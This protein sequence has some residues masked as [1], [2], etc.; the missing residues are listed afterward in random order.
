MHSRRTLSENMLW[1]L[2][3]VLGIHFLAVWLFLGPPDAAR[4][5]NGVSPR[6]LE[7]WTIYPGQALDLEFIL[8]PPG[9]GGEDLRLVA[10]FKKPVTNQGLVLKAGGDRIHGDIDDDQ[11]RYSLTTTTARRHLALANQGDLPVRLAE[12]HLRNYAA[13]NPNFPRLAVLWA[14]WEPER[15]VVLAWLAAVA[16]GGLLITLGGWL[17]PRPIIFWTLTAGPTLLLAAAGLGAAAGGLRP[18]LAWDCFWLSG[19]LGPALWLLARAARWAWGQAGRVWAVLRFL[20]RPRTAVFM[21]LMIAA[22]FLPPILIGGPPSRMPFNPGPLNHL[23]DYR[24]D[25]VII[26]NSMAYTRINYKK[27]EELVPGRKVTLV[28]LP[29][30]RMDSWYLM[31]KHYVVASGVKPKR[32]FLFFRDSHL[33]RVYRDRSERWVR[34]NEALS[35]GHDPEFNQVMYGSPD[36]FKKKLATGLLDVFALGN[37]GFYWRKHLKQWVTVTTIPPGFAEKYPV[38]TDKYWARKVNDRFGLAKLRPDIKEEYLEDRQALFDFDRELSQSLLPYFIDLAHKHDIPLMMIRVQCN[39]EPDGSVPQ[40]PELR[41][42]IADLKA[43]LAKEGVDFHDFT[44]DPEV[45]PELY[46]GTDHIW[47]KYRDHYTEIFYRRLKKY[48]Q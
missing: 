21:G 17:F 32:V 7:A 11:V 13:E 44:G 34:T 37:W 8:P 42:Y 5:W 26:G 25:F 45:T 43:Y 47:P 35:P 14:G 36:P 1:S 22:V 31:L 46:S 24:P 3:A 16:G 41:R 40:S 23:K 48:L 19:G 29:G 28:R 6:P 38:T 30:S 4:R 10:E 27:L 15:A 2:M 33:T 9:R 20:A 12:Y 39:P 18:V